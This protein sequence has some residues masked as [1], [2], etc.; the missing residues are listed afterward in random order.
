M[1]HGM[2]GVRFHIAKRVNEKCG[3]QIHLSKYTTYDCMYIV[4][5]YTTCTTTARCEID[6]A[7]DVMKSDV[8]KWLAKSLWPALIGA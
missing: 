2:R 6:A 4:Y 1:T 3:F 5:W 7:R 8:E